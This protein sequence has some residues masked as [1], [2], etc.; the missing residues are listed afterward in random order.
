M[1]R[2]FR[3]ERRVQ[4]AETD[5]AGVMHFSNYFRWMEEV[6]H[7]FFRS[8]GMSVVQPHGDATIS[9]PRVQVS[10]E[11]LAPL[12]FEDVVTIELTI[13]DVREKSVTYEAG[14]LTH[15]VRTARGRVKMVC[16]QMKDHRFTS[17]VIPDFIREKFD[18][19]G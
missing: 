6:E 12:R 17:V 4:F 11:Y 8:L 10:C 15:G 18:A 5:M 1:P 16:C 7:A 13:T 14:F 19:G 3:I 9:W 2:E